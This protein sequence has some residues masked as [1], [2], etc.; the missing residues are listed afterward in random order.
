[1]YVFKLEELSVILYSIYLYTYRFQTQS[2]DP[3]ICTHTSHN[4]STL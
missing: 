1:M 2:H 3:Y 4:E